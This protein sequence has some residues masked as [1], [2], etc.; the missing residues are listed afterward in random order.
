MSVAPHAPRSRVAEIGDIPEATRTITSAFERDPVWGWVLEGAD[1]SAV[2]AWWSILLTSGLRYGWLR[3][4]AAC[5]SVAL[6]IPPGGTELTP[7]EEEALGP[8]I[9]AL[10]N[11]RRGLFP[12]IIRLFEVSHPRDEPHFLLDLW[13]TMPAHQGTGL[14][15]VLIRDN[16]A[17]IDRAHAPA[18]LESTNDANL[19]RYAKLG[20]ERHG[21]F[22]LP[23]GGP[24]VTTMWRPAR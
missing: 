16:L 19:A 14:G 11:Q 13:G 3:V 21:S 7:E 2:L 24:T 6:W 22:T 12:E 5:E 15:G 8:I 9:D 17:E 1:P 4:S 20:F 18:Y 23:A 10:G